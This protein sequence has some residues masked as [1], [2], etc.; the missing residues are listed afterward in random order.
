MKILVILFVLFGGIYLLQQ[1]FSFLPL[2]ESYLKAEDMSN[3]TMQKNGES[4]MINFSLCKPEEKRFDVAFGSTTIQIVG[5]SDNLCVFKYGGEVE[6]PKWDGKLDTTCEVPLN[7]GTATFNT[8][9]TGI[10]FSSIKQYCS[11]E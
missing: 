6:N 7:Q 3:P 10:D 8:T 5:K 11:R 4:I 2:E 1:R 9:N